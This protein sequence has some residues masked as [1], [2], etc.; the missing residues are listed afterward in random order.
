MELAYKFTVISETFIAM[1]TVGS[2][3]FHTKMNR[4]MGLKRKTKIM[5]PDFNQCD[6]YQRQGF[7]IVHQCVDSRDRF[8]Q[9]YQ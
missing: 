3:S 7:V 1:L 6:E 2:C 4:G 5:N 8:V 9:C